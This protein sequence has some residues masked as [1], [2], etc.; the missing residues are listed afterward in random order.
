MILILENIIFFCILLIINFLVIK[1]YK[2]LGKKINI[3]DVPNEKRK[4]HK[5]P[6]PLIG[7]II[8][9]FNIFFLL[10]YVSFKK[11][12][13]LL[14]IFIHS[15]PKGLIYALLS[16]TGIFLIGLYD[17]KYKIRPSVRLL[18]LSILIYILL[19]TDQ[20]LLIHSINFSFPG[21]D[22][23]FKLGVFIFTFL[24]FLTLLISC[25][26]NDGINLQSAIFFLI[27]FIILYFITQNFL[28]LLIIFSLI[29]FSLLNFNG[30]IFLGDSGVYLL[31]ILLGFYFIKYY[32]YGYSLKADQV[33]LFLFFP[34]LDSARCF[35]YRLIKGKNIL[36]ADNLHFHH[37]LLKKINYSKT[38]IIITIFYLIPLGGYLFKI[39]TAHV[40]ILI[41]VG[42]FLVLFKVRSQKK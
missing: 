34:V 1:N 41:L 32:N 31:S 4:I 36:L 30:K 37:I 35:A 8:I 5:N 20:T 7:G 29:I 26:L 19:K 33:F 40:L 6:V 12:D 3:Y 38:I 23:N 17:D 22:I 25:N 18:L 27:N 10:I 39:S 24:C 21:Y 9:Y 13:H 14:N 16:F 15:E 2:Y 28:I 11:N 42:Y